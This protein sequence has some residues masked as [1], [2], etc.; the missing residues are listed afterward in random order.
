MA[1]NEHGKMRRFGRLGQVWGAFMTLDGALTAAFYGACAIATSGASAVA[2]GVVAGAGAI[3]AA[4]GTWVFKRSGQVAHHAQRHQFEAERAAAQP[5]RGA[6]LTDAGSDLSPSP[7]RGPEVD[8]A[9]ANGPIEVKADPVTAGGV[10]NARVRTTLETPEIA[11]PATG[12]EPEA[13]VATPSA[14]RGFG[15]AG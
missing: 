9:D 15:L 11:A 5:A 2:N 6:A 13:A 3:W 4:I 7:S 1:G 12:V 14:G 10:G 8:G